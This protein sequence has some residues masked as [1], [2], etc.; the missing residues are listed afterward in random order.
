M[1]GRE[2]VDARLAE[3]SVVLKAHDVLGGQGVVDTG[4]HVVIITTSR[5]LRSIVFQATASGM[6]VL[7]VRT[8][9]ICSVI[10]EREVARQ[11]VVLAVERQ[12]CGIGH[13]VLE[14]QYLGEAGTQVVLDGIVGK[15]LDDCSGT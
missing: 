1:A 8:A 14:I 11:L 13:L 5:I 2:Q 6:C 7:R 4:E 15:Q 10:S 3:F 12:G 9:G